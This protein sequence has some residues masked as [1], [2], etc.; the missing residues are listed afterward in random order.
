MNHS[1]CISEVLP[2]FPGIAFTKTTDSV[3]ASSSNFAARL[4]GFRNA[5]QLQGCSDFDVRC[6]AAESAP[7]FQREDR[8]VITTDRQLTFVHVNVYAQDR[9]CI[10]LLHKSPL[11]DKFDNTVGLACIA[12]EISQPQIGRAL[13]AITN[14]N[15]KPS[16]QIRNHRVGMSGELAEL[17]ERE[18][19]LLFY[20]VNGSSLKESAAVLGLSLRTIETYLGRIKRKF[21]CTTK[22]QVINFA[23][24]HGFTHMIPRRILKLALGHSF[25]F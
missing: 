13:Y 1:P 16:S 15:A 18:A 17:S 9:P 23:I 24:E 2:Q 12:H 3:Y 4:Y 5:S 22:S 7:E 20:L 21:Q 19:E 10:I 11:K 6:K 25:R 14:L 8:E